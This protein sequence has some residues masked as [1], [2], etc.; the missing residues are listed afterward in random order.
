MA[1]PAPQTLKLRAGDL[2]LD[3]VPEVGG[4]IA[5]FRTGTVDLMRSA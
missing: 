5:G 2:A 1:T 3:L 4:G